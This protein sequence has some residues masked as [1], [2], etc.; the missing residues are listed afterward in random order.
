MTGKNEKIRTI[1]IV[2]DIK[3]NA[4]LLEA[5]L[6][7]EYLIRTASRGSEALEVA[8]E[9]LP[10][11]IL[12]DIMMPDMNGYDVC[13]ALKANS[14]TKKIPVIFVTAL[15][16]PGDETRGFEAGG[17]DYLTKPVIGSIVRV[18]VKAH[19]ALKEA[20]EA[21][22]EWNSNLKKR[23]L[24]SIVNIRIKT[25]ELM[26]AEERAC[27]LHGYTQSVELL[28]GVFELMEDSFGISSR[29]VS[30]LAG[31]AARQ[32][33][34]SGEEVSKVRLAGLLHDVGTLGAGRGKSDKL[35]AEMS[36]NERTE[37]H[38]HP[39]RG[40]DLFASL[41]DLHDLGLMVRSHHEAYNGSGFPDGLQGDDIPLGAR[42][43][44]IADV[45]EHAA[46]SVSHQRDE[47]ALVTARR[48]A[49]MLL[50][51]RLISYF[52][53][54]TRILY[55][56]KK[57]TGTTGEIEVPPNEL[58]SGMQLSRD[59]SNDAGVLLLQKGDLLDSVGIALIRHNSRMNTSPNGGVWM[60]IGA[61]ENREG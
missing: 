39:L 24:Q 41:E 47:Y 14:D 13:R 2:D 40:Q 12:L 59:L 37:F 23:L 17:V 48:H 21:L 1:L 9:T 36:A 60:Y 10:D 32:M 26:S 31:D 38:S 3:E 43:V 57:K 61:D 46:N 20:Q 16:N 58:I 35:E 4:D 42:L 6:S 27:G 55:F 5:I 8:S 51:P 15:L 33:G 7:A 34:L 29:A 30:E 22:E 54:I 19:L 28:S 25:E 56:E 11:L 44:A 52:T 53:M 45:I 49:G 18:R 50:D